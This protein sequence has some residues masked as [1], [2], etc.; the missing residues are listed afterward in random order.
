MNL[1][2]IPAVLLK[3]QHPE[4]QKGAV[5]ACVMEAVAY[6]AGEPWSDRPACASPICTSF[7]ISLNDVIEDDERRTELLKPLIPL[8]AGSRTNDADEL[9]RSYLA[10]DWLIR[11]YLPTWLSLVPALATNA[12]ALLELPPITDASGFGASVQELLQGS[13]RRSAAAGDA[14]WDAAGA[15]AGAAL[16][17]TVVALQKSA[18]KLLDRMIRVEEAA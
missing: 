16:R 9:K 7:A 14:A 13:R 5:D 11:V 17:P 2:L 1:E 18:L 15:A 8:L 6:V 12:S 3:G 4:G 10:L